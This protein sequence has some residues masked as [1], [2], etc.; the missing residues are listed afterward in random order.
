[1]HAAAVVAAVD[2]DVDVENFLG[3]TMERGFDVYTVIS[4]LLSL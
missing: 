4:M 1:V 2:V 3:M